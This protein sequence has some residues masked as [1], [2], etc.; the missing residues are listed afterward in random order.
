MGDIS[1]VFEHSHGEWATPQAFYDRLNYL[2]GPFTLDP[3]ASAENA[4]CEKFFTE[5]ENGLERSWIGHRCFVNPP[6][7]QHIDKWLA[8]AYH[9]AMCYGVYSLC[10]LPARTET[11]WFHEEAQRATEIV[12]VRGRIAFESGGK[13]NGNPLGSILVIFD[14]ARRHNWPKEPWRSQM[15]RD[16]KKEKANV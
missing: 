4:K 7:K 1:K 16:G 2:Y 3:C 11:A 9:E 12:E 8:W 5:K 13:K 14:G 6:Y 10:V 15:D